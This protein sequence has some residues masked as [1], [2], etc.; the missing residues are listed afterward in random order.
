MGYLTLPTA[1]RKDPLGPGRLNALRGNLG[2]LRSLHA[3]EHNPGTGEH[4]CMEVPRIV[5]RFDYAAGYT[6]NPAGTDDVSSISNPAVGEVVLTLAANRFSANNTLVEVSCAGE[7]RP[8]V[9]AYKLTSA[10]SLTIYLRELTSALGAGNAWAAVDR[11]F[12]VAIHAP[13]TSV[14]AAAALP[15]SV[16]RSDTMR[17]PDDLLW[18]AHVL[19]QQ[20]LKSMVG[21]AH[22]LW[23]G[24][25]AV[26]TVAKYVDAR[27]AF[28]SATPKYTESGAE[29]ISTY[30]STGI[31]DL[32]YSSLN[33]SHPFLSVDYARTSPTP[34]SADDI[35]VVNTSQT[36][37]TTTRAYLYKYDA[38]ANTWARGDADFFA[39][40]YGGA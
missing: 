16:L 30:V 20:T 8:C 35:F 19:Q 24:V 4:N 9:A 12:N 28:D 25:H 29:I 6:K 22:T 39:V 40:I 33:P 15:A 37:N 3:K 21:A 34:G 18:N 23:T 11:T 13:P 27:I 36:S 26:R 10:T 5:T 38:S 31:V 14:T 32:A 1:A 7:A 17:S 2:W